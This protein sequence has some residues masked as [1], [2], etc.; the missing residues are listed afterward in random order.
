MAALYADEN[1]PRRVADVLRLLGHDVLTAQDAGRANQRIPDLDQLQFAVSLG[2]AVLTN[3]GW[4]YH[5]L[6]ATVPS[7]SGIITFTDDRDE[8]ELANRIHASIS[9]PPA[10]SGKLIRV[11]RPARP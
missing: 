5:R 6:H 7:H 1:V 11:T 8:D 9:L 4:D 3:N 10:L 2:R